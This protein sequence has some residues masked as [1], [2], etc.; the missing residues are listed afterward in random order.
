MPDL[1]SPDSNNIRPPTTIYSSIYFQ[2]LAATLVVLSV[3]S[4]ILSFK[5]SGNIT[6]FFRIGDTL[7][8]SPLLSQSDL[9]I[10]A[11]KTGHDGQQFLTIALDPLL[12]NSASIEVLDNPSYR[13]RRILYPLLGYL[14]GL[15]QSSKIPYALVA[16]NGACIV[17][18]VGI[19]HHFFRLYKKPT[20]Y[21]LLILILPPIWIIFSIGTAG[22]LS[23]ML[24]LA[25][26]YFYQAEKQQVSFVFIAIGCLARETLLAFLA[27][28]IISEFLKKRWRQ[29]ILALTAACPVLLWN[30]YISWIK[31]PGNDADKVFHVSF[32]Y[33][34]LGI[35]Q[36]LKS[37]LSEGLNPVNMFD[38]LMFFL[39]I[40]SFVSI[41][42]N[43]RNHFSQARLIAISASIYVTMFTC[44]TMNILGHFADYSRVYGDVYIF[45][46][47]GLAFSGIDKTRILLSLYGI[48]SIGYIFAFTR[49]FA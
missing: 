10:H 26:I 25:A 31:F 32:S 46:V 17:A 34:L 48:A 21:A 6:G 40:Y 7:G 30:A 2:I 35:T 43:I 15:G 38:C 3:A 4:V 11:G 37:F 33:P 41:A 39:L 44:T 29:A 23:G 27:A 19:S 1:L 49:E 5:F 47:L 20:Y 22:L 9:F 16:I 12:R 36:K 14:L 13:Y 24:L 42:R 8:L 45:T 28:L 18:M